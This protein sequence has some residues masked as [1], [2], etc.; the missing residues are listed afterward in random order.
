LRRQASLKRPARSRLAEPH[1]QL[2]SS[3]RSAKRP[4]GTR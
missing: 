1:H 3:R 2:P 4:A